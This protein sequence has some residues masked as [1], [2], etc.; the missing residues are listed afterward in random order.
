MV[1][2]FSSWD[3]AC[4]SEHWHRWNLRFDDFHD[5]AT[6]TADHFR[7]LPH[8]RQGLI[9]VELEEQLYHL[10]ELFAIGMEKAKVASPSEALRQDM[11]QQQPQELFTAKRSELKLPGLAV[12]VT[13][14]DVAVTTG[15]N[16]L[17]LNHA[18]V[19]VATQI[20]QCLLTRAD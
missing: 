13:E 4:V 15:N 7:S 9:G 3:S 2:T 17:L 20:D 10:N 12:S 16:V 14:G 18:A 6:G 11:L 5:T 19:K 8:P 1:F